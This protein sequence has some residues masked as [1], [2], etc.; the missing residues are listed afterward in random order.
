MLESQCLLVLENHIG[1]HRVSLRKHCSA[2]LLM[3]GLLF[4][5]C[6]LLCGRFGAHT[7]FSSRQTYR[8][9]IVKCQGLPNKVANLPMGRCP[10][11][12][13]SASLHLATKL[14]N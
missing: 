5:C 8:G 7:G 9:C 2:P 11:L 1:Q 12:P 4:L 13:R 6:A 14:C 10:C 3:K